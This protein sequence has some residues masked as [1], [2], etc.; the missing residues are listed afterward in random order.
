MTSMRAKKTKRPA[1]GYGK[2]PVRTRFKKGR[3]GNPKGRPKGSRNRLGHRLAM[4]ELV[5]VMQSK[6]SPTSLKMKAAQTI[7]H[8][9]ML[10]VDEPDEADE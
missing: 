3:S 4:D 7:L 1:V 9:A 5:R 10:G 8:L 2:P 6:K